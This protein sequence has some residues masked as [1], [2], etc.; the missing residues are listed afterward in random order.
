MNRRFA[1][2]LAAYAILGILVLVTLDG[3]FRIG[4]LIIL[5][6]IA[7]KTWLA[8]LKQRQD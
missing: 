8:V 2:A 5:G 6:G 1:A 3:E 4:T 7:L